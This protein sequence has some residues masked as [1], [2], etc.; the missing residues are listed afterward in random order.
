MLKKVKQICEDVEWAPDFKNK[1]LLPSEC[2]SIC[3]FFYFHRTSLTCLFGVFKI[4]SLC[5]AN[6]TVDV[7]PFFALFVLIF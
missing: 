6:F 1:M 4:K 5:N 2:F 7:T 3:S